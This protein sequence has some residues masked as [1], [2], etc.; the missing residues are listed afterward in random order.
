[1]ASRFTEVSDHGFL[2]LFRHVEMLRKTAHAQELRHA[3]VDEFSVQ[4][5]PVRRNRAGA[6]P[7][8][9]TQDHALRFFGVTMNMRQA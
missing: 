4:P 5:D 9:R 7:A 8:E 6:F 3:S 1:M 2:F